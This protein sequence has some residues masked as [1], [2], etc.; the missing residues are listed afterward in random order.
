MMGSCCSKD[1]SNAHVR[2]VQ[3]TEQE[4]EGDRI[5]EGRLPDADSLHIEE[6]LS[7][8]E[9]TIGTRSL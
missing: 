8:E 2:L 3:V 5:D 9:M 4:R 1:K 7:R 6:Q